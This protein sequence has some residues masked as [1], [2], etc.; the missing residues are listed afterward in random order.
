MSQGI[1]I[2]LLL[3]LLY[4]RHIPS[5]ALRGIDQFADDT[6]FGHLERTESA[7]RSIGPWRTI[8]AFVP[9]TIR[10]CDKYIGLDIL[11]YKQHLDNIN[12]NFDGRG[13]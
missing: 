7:T 3:H 5:P 8:S 12:I 1:I 11:K 9:V 10:K 6:A 4:V 13:T 2:T